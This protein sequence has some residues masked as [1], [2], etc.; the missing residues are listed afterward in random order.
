MSG[1]DEA[2]GLAVGDGQVE[3]KRNKGRE[4]SNSGIKGR[5]FRFLS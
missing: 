3:R 5:C 2:I 1:G 4:E